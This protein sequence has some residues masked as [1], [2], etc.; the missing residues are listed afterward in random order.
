MDGVKRPPGGDPD[1]PRPVRNRQ[2]LARALKALQARSGM[3]LRNVQDQTRSQRDPLK[4][5]TVSEMLNAQRL[6]PKRMVLA[7]VGVLGVTSTD[8]LSAWEAAYERVAMAEALA[9]SQPSPDQA[10][11]PSPL[12][13]VV[14]QAVSPKRFPNLID[15]LLKADRLEDALQLLR[16]RAADHNDVARQLNE[17]LAEYDREEE[18][19]TRAEAGDRDAARK[20]AGWQITVGRPDEARQVLRSIADRE[21][22][23]LEEMF[24]DVLLHDLGQPSA[25]A[26]LAAAGN[27]YA[28]VQL[29]RWLQQDGSWQK[30]IELLRPHAETGNLEAATELV[31]LLYRAGQAPDLRGMAAA[32]NSRAHQ[33]WVDLLVDRQREAE[34][35]VLAEDG[36]AYA[37]ERLVHQLSDA[38]RVN[39]AIDL[40]LPIAK[41]GDEY[42]IKWLARLYRDARG[43]ERIVQDL[44]PVAKEGNR[45]AAALV[46][47]LMEEN[48]PVGAAR[49][50]LSHGL[51][52]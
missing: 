30:G 50:R 44:L 15:D 28:L 45:A 4:R 20:L 23:D 47:E 1:D 37:T 5:S 22:R 38:S 33:R 32:G 42:A 29:A 40:L 52:E 41:I 49:L 17:L 34:L 35:R 12:L 48:D 13:A 19:H 31:E 16:I 8:D 2:D 51:D 27:T 10:P 9:G 14:L 26:D 43:A 25:V 24:I 39:E 3:S 7:L 36:D 21:G 18:L 11:P 46:A 6:I